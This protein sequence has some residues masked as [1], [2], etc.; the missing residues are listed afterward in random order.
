MVKTVIN[1]GIVVAALGVANL[2]QAQVAVPKIEQVKQTI[3]AE[4]AK[5]RPGVQV[6]TI[7]ESEVKD[8]Y[9]VTIAH[10]QSFYSTADGKN[11]FVGNLFRVQPGKVVN[12]TEEAKNGDRAK[13][14]AALKTKDL[15]SF[16]A[17]GEKKK[18]IYVFTDVDC[19]YCQKLHANMAQM[20]ELG[21]EV[22]YL[23]YP[24]AGINSQ[25][26]NKIAS[27]WCAK[28]KQ[29]AITKLKAKTAIDINV[30]DGNPVAN[31]FQLGQQL[32]LSGTPALIT[33][34]GELI[35]GYMDAPA[36]AQRLGL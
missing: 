21:I 14:V 31:Q 24:R 28:D 12:V 33:E 23:A 6:E 26:Y 32:G 22:N 36:L 3:N 25:S 5:A 27:A 16:P 30:C 1:G 9:K 4:W 13:A 11:F 19:Y 29:D 8:I 17:K 2:V 34:D 18:A 20:N 15:I 7:E 10:G 35:A